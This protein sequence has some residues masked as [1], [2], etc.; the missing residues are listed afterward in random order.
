VNSRIARRYIV[1]VFG[2]KPLILA[3]LALIDEDQH[4]VTVDIADLQM[5][6]FA[7][8]ETT[9]VGHAEDGPVSEPGPM[10]NLLSSD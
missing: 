9:A 1:C 7:R 8:P 6:D 10:T 2:S 4:P 5:P 3:P